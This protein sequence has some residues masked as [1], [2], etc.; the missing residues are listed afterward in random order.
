[1]EKP[2]RQLRGGAFRQQA[3]KP[4]PVVGGHPSGPRVSARLVR[5]RPGS[6]GRA[7]LERSPI[8]SCTGRGLPSRPVTRP[9]V[10]SCRT[11]SP[12]PAPL[13][14]P[15]AVCFLL[16]F[17]SAFAGWTLSSALLCGVRTFLGTLPSELAKRRGEPGRRGHPACLITIPDAGPSC[18]GLAPGPASEP[19]LWFPRGVLLE[20]AQD[21]GRHVLP[22]LMLRIAAGAQGRDPPC[23]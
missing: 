4:D 12:L 11:V 15:L 18:F 7:T 22:V 2:L 5:P 23:V 19:R 1:M 20:V 9:L 10:R 17:P 6:I 21:V 8:W 13:S 16:R 3:C 14:R